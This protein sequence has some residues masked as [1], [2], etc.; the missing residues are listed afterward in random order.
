LQRN[1]NYLHTEKPII[2][3]NVG[4]YSSEKEVYFSQEA[5]SSK[6]DVNGTSLARLVALD[7]YLSEEERSEITYIKMDIEGAETE[8]LK[9]MAQT[10]AKYKP[11]LAIC[12]YHL[13][14]DLWQI[15]EYIHSLNPDYKLYI[16][17]H[18]VEYGAETVCY[19]IP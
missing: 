6:I 15:P 11:K 16:R 3:H 9:G 8:A 13:P 4:L 1:I 19:A 5:S 2:V 12:I 14:D 18:D 7:T 10:I 17:H